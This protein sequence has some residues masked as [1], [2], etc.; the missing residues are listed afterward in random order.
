MGSAC[1]TC[2]REERCI[3]D[4]GEGKPRERDH[5]EHMRL[6]RGNIKTNLQKIG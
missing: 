5:F 4:F 6:D 2:G 1:G 3:Q